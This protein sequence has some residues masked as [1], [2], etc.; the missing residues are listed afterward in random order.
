[1]MNPMGQGRLLTA[2]NHFQTAD[3]EE[4]RGVRSQGA[5]TRELSGTVSETL[6]SSS[7]QAWPFPKLSLGGKS[8]FGFL[9]PGNLKSVFTT[10][11]FSQK[12]I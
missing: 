4:T 5:Q 2:L 9:P 7:E 3:E 6:P 11:F 12:L 8:Y 10:F 1:M